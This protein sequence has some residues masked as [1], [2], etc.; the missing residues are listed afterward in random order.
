M[1]P[2]ETNSNNELAQDL[3]KSLQVTTALM[4]DLLGEIRDNATSLAVLKEKLEGI[5]EKVKSLSH[6]VRDDNGNKSLITRLALLEKELEN[7][8]EALEESKEERTEIHT[9]ISKVKDSLSEDK[10]TE[11]EFNKE[12][13]V[14]WLKLAAVIAP[15][16]LALGLVIAKFF[17]G[18]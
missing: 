11:A 12:K 18:N 3:A 7:M 5:E 4:Q 15:G 10:K 8:E 17:L 14:S 16:L 2:S 6:I 1:P 13:T 9:R